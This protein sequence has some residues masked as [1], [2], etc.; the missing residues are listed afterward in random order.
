M[1][2]VVCAPDPCMVKEGVVTIHRFYG[3]VHSVS[4]AKQIVIFLCVSSVFI[5]WSLIIHTR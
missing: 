5:T 2:C 4:G 1:V 3:H